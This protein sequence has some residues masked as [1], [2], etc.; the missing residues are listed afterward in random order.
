MCTQQQSRR[1]DHGMHSSF[2][3]RKKA[4]FCG[5]AVLDYSRSAGKLSL[6]PVRTRLLEPIKKY[7]D[8]ILPVIGASASELLDAFARCCEISDGRD[9]L[10]LQRTGSM[11]SGRRRRTNRRTVHPEGVKNYDTYPLLANL[12]YGVTQRHSNWQKTYSPL[13]SA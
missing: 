2:A 4:F 12:V 3:A 11:K 8:G 10:T 1:L 9:L 5:W 7:V 13:I 6:G